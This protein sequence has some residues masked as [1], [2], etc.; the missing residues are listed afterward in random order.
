MIVFYHEF[1]QLDRFG[2]NGPTPQILNAGVDIFFVISG[3]IMWHTTFGKGVDQA[4]FLKHR[5]RRIV[6][7]YWIVTTFYL[8]VLLSKPSWM[9]S[10]QFSL[11]HVI[12]SY[13]FIPAAHPANPLEMWPLVVPG[14][15]LNCEMFFYLLFSFSLVLSSQLRIIALQAMIIGLVAIHYIFDLPENSILGFY[16]SNIMLEFAFGVAL[17]Y[18]CSTARPVG[19]RAAAAVFVIGIISFGVVAIA[20]DALPNIRC[21][22]FG[23]PSLLVVAGAVLYER[24]RPIPRIPLLE[25]VGNS[26]YSLYLIHGSVL[27]FLAQLWRHSNSLSPNSLPGMVSFMA[28][29]V[30][31]AVIAGII[32][33]RTIEKPMLRAFSR[34]EMVSERRE[35]ATW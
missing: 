4:T 13:L 15:S 35:I 26:S 23:L 6:P 14:W 3:F 19:F 18:L 21:I 1:V 17:G 34:N 32:V 29:G 31:L 28:V 27:S 7:L 22:T 25:L 11:Y 16:T 33:Y 9:Q 8:V 12:A 2:Y 30:V 24:S 20:P 10:G 5:I